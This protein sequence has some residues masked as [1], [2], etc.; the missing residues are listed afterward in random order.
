MGY[1]KIDNI[2]KKFGG[3]QALENINFEI[4]E[5][6]FVCL[7]GPSGCGK[8]TLLR[9]ISGLEDE[10]SGKVYLRDEDITNLPPAK[11]N[12]GIVFQSYVLFPNMT[13]GENIAYGLKSRKLPNDEIHKRVDEVLQLVGLQEEKNKYPNKLSGGQQQRV[14]I[15]RAIAL[16]PKILLLDEPLSALDAKV[17]EHLRIEIKNIQRTLGITTVMVTHDQEEAL[18]MADKIVVMNNAKVEQIG[19]PEEIYKNPTNKFVADFVGNI[20]FFQYKGKNRALRPEEIKT[21]VEP[22]EGYEK[23]KIESMEFRGAFYRAI[24]NLENGIKNIMIDFISVKMEERQYKPGD[25]IYLNLEDGI[26]I[27]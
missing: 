17:R 7:L 25:I 19:T 13:A 10:T 1:L 4:E 8:T 24:V 5:G 3:F 18:T 6:E 14:A 27:E 15:A 20:N 26:I 21:S 11:R 16:S 23:G 22:Q 2:N 9:I 12:F